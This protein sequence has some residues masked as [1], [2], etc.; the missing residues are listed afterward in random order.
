[1]DHHFPISTRFN[2]KTS[3]AVP[4]LHDLLRDER[5]H[6]PDQR[7]SPGWLLIGAILALLAMLLVFHYVVRG[8]LWQS[9]LRHKAVAVHAQAIWRC[10][11]LQGREVSGAC[12]LQASAEA[13]RVALL[14]FR[15]VP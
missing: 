6:L 4:H 2:A 13:R 1:M 12:L 11:N 14:H 9:E 15:D 10:N 8:S 5:H 3:S 7:R